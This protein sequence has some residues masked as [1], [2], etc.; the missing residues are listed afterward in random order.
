MKTKKIP[1]TSKLE[2]LCWVWI[3][4]FFSPFTHSRELSSCCELETLNTIHP[5][6]RELN[7]S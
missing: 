1:H 5:Q 6:Y 2:D 3:I 7:T 4:I